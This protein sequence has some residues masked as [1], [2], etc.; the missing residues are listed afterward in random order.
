MS[1][2]NLLIYRVSWFIQQTF[3]SNSQ[4][5]DF[6]STKMDVLRGTGKAKTNNSLKWVK[7]VM[8][9]HKFP[10][11]SW[12]D[13][14]Q[15]FVIWNSS[16]SNFLWTSPIS[17]P[18]L[19]NLGNMG[20]NIKRSQIKNLFSQNIIKLK[21]WVLSPIRKN[22]ESEAGP[23]KKTRPTLI[24]FFKIYL[25][26]ALKKL[27]GLP[28]CSSDLAKSS[29]KGLLTSAEVT[30]RN[31]RWNTGTMWRPLLKKF[32][33][34]CRRDW[35]RSTSMTRWG[36]NS[37]RNFSLW[38]L[39][40][41]RNLRKQVVWNLRSKICLKGGSGSTWSGQVTLLESTSKVML[42]CNGIRNDIF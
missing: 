20:T 37:I 5:K 30:T 28:K 14:N 36:A 25:I 22:L 33:G 8:R 9:S 12:Y 29:R 27:E 3:L 21:K 4:T 35:P 34:K 40:R 11:F 17:C 41:G 38:S 6:L 24:S 15:Y 26:S 7:V 23:P 16:T 42:W 2:F 39:F 32:R 31:C 18:W 19:W 1:S 10:V 13:Y